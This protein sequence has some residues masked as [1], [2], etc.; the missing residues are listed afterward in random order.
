MSVGTPF[1]PR[2]APLNTKMQWRE[3]AG[4]FASS[5]YADHHD[6]EYNA[7]REAAAV[8]DVSPLYKYRVTGPDALR[9]ADRVVTRDASKLK[10]GQVMYTPW[11]DEHGKVVDDGTVHRNVPSSRPWMVPSS[12]TL[13]CSSHHGV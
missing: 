2:T 13:P 3:W 7:I 12:M 9:L 11:C 10:V 4:Y 5:A 6:I 1:H 8:I